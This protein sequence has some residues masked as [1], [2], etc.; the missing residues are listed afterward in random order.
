MKTINV[1]MLG[2]IC[3]LMLMGKVNAE[4]KSLND[5]KLGFGFDRGFGVVGS[6]DKVNGFIG[7]KG[8]AIDYIFMKEAMNVELDGSVFW[9]IGGGGYGDWDRDSDRDGDFGA[10]LPVGVEWYFEKNVD[11]F[12]QLI[13][14]I[15]IHDKSKFGLSFSIGVRFQL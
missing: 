2:F 12:A 7:N 15:Q 10:R 6:I 1:T 3:V 13:P 8:F 14:R 5:I 11:V 9:Y 4:E